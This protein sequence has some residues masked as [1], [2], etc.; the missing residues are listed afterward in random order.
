M[1][2]PLTKNGLPLS[3]KQASSGWT[4]PTQTTRFL[5]PNGE[6]MSRASSANGWLQ[7]SLAIPQWTWQALYKIELMESGYDEH[8]FQYAKADLENSRLLDIGHF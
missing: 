8:V 3:E 2:Q 1:Q 5:Q 4:Y 7:S 6:K